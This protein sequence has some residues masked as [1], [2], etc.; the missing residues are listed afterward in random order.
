M[1]PSCDSVR[2]RF[3]V[4]DALDMSMIEGW[5]ELEETKA[6]GKTHSRTGQ[7]NIS[8]CETMDYRRGELV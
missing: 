1:S 8:Q 5:K 4:I 7:P 2:L 3:G 6:S